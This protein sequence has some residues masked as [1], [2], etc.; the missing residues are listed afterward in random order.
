[1]SRIRRAAVV[2]MGVVLALTAEACGGGSGDR[3][4]HPA[5]SAASATPA[6]GPTAAPTPSSSL[7]PTTAQLLRGSKAVHFRG[8][9][10]IRLAGRLFGSG[11]V[12]VV[13]SHQGG[14]A[15]NQTDWWGMARLL[16]DRG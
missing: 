8:P 13:L 10:G 4:A 3:S 2:G 7:E 16:S 14:T 6:A 11:A 15:A 1:M 12:G 5:I 9:D